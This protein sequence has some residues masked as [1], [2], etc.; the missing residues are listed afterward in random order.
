MSLGSRALSA[1]HAAAQRLEIGASTPPYTGPS[2]EK[3]Q[4]QSAPLVADLEA[5]MRAERTR[6]SRGNDTA[7]AMNY[8]LKRWP[9]FSRF[10]GDGRIC[11]S[12]NAAER[13]MRQ[14]DR[15]DVISKCAECGLLMQVDLGLIIRVSGP[16]TVLWNRKAR[17]RRLG[18]LGWVEFQ[19]RAPGM[20][21]HEALTAPPE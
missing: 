9:S 15:W 16:A 1:L 20:V 18:C 10:L 19:A 3:R 8:M 7:K 17:C 13:A 12:N 11:L 6:L 2:V 21:M 14:R 5:W 4:A